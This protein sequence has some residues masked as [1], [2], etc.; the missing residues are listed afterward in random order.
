[1]L[2]LLLRHILLPLKPSQ[3]NHTGM[4]KCERTSVRLA[5]IA[6]TPTPAGID[7]IV[8]V[9]S[10]P[11]HTPDESSRIRRYKMTIRTCCT[12]IM[13][14]CSVVD[15]TRDSRSSAGTEHCG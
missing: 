2:L 6:G 4:R 14:G 7:A 15:I 10:R 13:S 1:L 3:N 8:H 5:Q 12:R 9:P 11:I